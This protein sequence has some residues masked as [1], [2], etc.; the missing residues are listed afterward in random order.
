MQHAAAD[1]DDLG[2]HAFFLEPGGLFDGD[3]VKRV[4][5]YFDVGYIDAGA[6]RFDAD[7]DVVIHNAFDGDLDLDDCLLPFLM[8][9][10]QCVK[11][12]VVPHA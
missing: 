4:L 5:A 1:G 7:L 11:P 6:I 9:R 12:W 2:H 10:T 8:S 3:L